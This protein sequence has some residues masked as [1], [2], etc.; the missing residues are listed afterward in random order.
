MSGKDYLTC[1]LPRETASIISVS[2]AGVEIC[3][4][5]NAASVSRSRDLPLCARCMWMSAGNNRGAP[6]N[7]NP[8][9]HHT[10]VRYGDVTL[11]QLVKKWS[12]AG[13]AH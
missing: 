7:G 8:A 4:N 10:C 2:S 11:L 13:W 3:M 6:L 9:M 5:R 1:T 12:T